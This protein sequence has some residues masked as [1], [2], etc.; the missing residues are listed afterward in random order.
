M[1]VLVLLFALLFRISALSQTILQ[2]EGDVQVGQS[3]TTSPTAGTIRWTGTDF[4]GWN[5][6]KWVSLT[7]GTVFD[8]T[9]TDVDEHLYHTIKIGTQEWM[10]ENLRTSHYADGSLIPMVNAA[11]TWQNTTDGAWCWYDSSSTYDAVYGKLYNFYAVVDARGLCPTGWHEPTDAEWTT[12]ITFLDPAAVVVAG[13]QS[14]VAGGS[15]KEKGPSHWAYP[16]TGTNETGF[17]ALGGGWR[18]LAGTFSSLG[19]TGFFWSSSLNATQ[20]WFRTLQNNM[21]VVL[22]GSMEKNLGY[23]VRCLKD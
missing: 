6:F 19:F 11:S 23:S 21:D 20:G 22:R 1:K 17:S 16:N 4:L 10:T 14:Q 12:M 18:S 15:L 3:N 9:I 8:G 5:G 13:T 7:Q 2:V